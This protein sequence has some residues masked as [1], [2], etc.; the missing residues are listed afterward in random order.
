MD[1]L[2]NMQI[3]ETDAFAETDFTELNLE[4]IGFDL[5]NPDGGDSSEEIMDGFEELGGLDN[6]DLDETDDPENPEFKELES[7]FDVSGDISL[8]GSSD[9][10]C[11]EDGDI[12]S[13]LCEDIGNLDE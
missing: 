7:L 10:F 8:S 9:D 4:D 13:L 1:N 6:T 5:D 3:N 2:L 12:E 11:I